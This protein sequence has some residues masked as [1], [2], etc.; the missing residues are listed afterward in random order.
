MWMAKQSI[1]VGFIFLPSF[2]GAFAGT[3]STKWSIK[4]ATIEAVSLRCK[5]ISQSDM[6]ISLHSQVIAAG[7]TVVYDWGDDYYNDGMGLNP[8]TWACSAVNGDAKAFDLAPFSTSW[9][10]AVDLKIS[11]SKGGLVLSMSKAP[12]A[13]PKKAS[14]RALSPQQPTLK[15]SRS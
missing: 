9:G 1:I 10:E 2:S 11:G 13:A 3:Y 6:A 8:G 4:N 12:N 15:A 14:S 7:A 5:N